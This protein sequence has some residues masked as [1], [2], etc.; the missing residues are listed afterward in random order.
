MMQSR[1]LVQG[2]A[3]LLVSIPHMG[4]Y[5]PPDIRARLNDT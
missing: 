3:P 2:R 4:T 1:R 5:L